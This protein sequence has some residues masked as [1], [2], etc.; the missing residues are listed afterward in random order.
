MWLV[1]GPLA[2]GKPPV[3]QVLHRLATGVCEWFH[4][5]GFQPMVLWQLTQFALVGMCVP[6]LPVAELP[7]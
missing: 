5:V 2:G 6:A 1:V 4:L 3:W 7:L